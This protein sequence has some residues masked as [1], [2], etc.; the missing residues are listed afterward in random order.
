MRAL[1]FLALLCFV[2]CNAQTT[3]EPEQA[4]HP[5]IPKRGKKVLLLR[6]DPLP[7]PL[8]IPGDP[9]KRR[10]TLVQ[11]TGEIPSDKEDAKGS[12]LL[13]DIPLTFNRFGDATRPGAKKA[14]PI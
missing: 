10:I 4:Q 6:S 11:I 13:D 1:G 3:P 9:L 8:I 12:I 14:E 2:G 7:T 5:E